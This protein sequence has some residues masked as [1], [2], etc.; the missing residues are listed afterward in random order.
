[1]TE[2]TAEDVPIAEDKKS[3]TS[4]EISALSTTSEV[5]SNKQSPTLPMAYPFRDPQWEK[6]ENAYHT[7][8]IDELNSLTRSYN[9]MAPKIAQ[10]PYYTLSR[11][12]A[13]C[14]ADV[15]PILADEIAQRARAPTVK[16]EIIGHREGGIMEKFGTG[17][18]AKVRD[19]D[20]KKGYGFKEFWRD[21]FRREEG[22]KA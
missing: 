1:M 10:R 6:T 12:L 19:E 16:V 22:M 2:T 7:L 20:I 17:H 3:M 9:L 5:L 11:E 13:R 14:F 8:A 15:A 18:V 4:E 21:L